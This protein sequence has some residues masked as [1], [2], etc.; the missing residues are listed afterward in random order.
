MPGL[1]FL[2][3]LKF[4]H[5]GDGRFDLSLDMPVFHTNLNNSTMARFS[6]EQQMATVG[7]DVDRAFNWLKKGNEQYARNAY[8]RALELIDFTIADPRNRDR[9]RAAMEVRERLVDT[10]DGPNHSG[11]TQV[12]WREYFEPFERAYAM[13]K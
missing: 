9:A 13:G 12:T 5:P 7:A 2:G 1:C 10:F 6:F 11:S 3:G 8:L 4:C